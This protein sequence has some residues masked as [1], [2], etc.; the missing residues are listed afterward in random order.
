MANVRVRFF[1][2]DAVGTRPGQRDGAENAPGRLEPCVAEEGG[3]S[4]SPHPRRLFRFL[5]R[6]DADD[7]PIVALLALDA[8]RAQGRRGAGA[9]EKTLQRHARRPVPS[10]QHGAPNFDYF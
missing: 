8:P 10:P 1:G 4:F 9:T 7:Q 3:R 2:L 6:D 5:C